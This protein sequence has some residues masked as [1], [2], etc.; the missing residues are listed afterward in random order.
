MLIPLVAIAQL[1][2]YLAS[3]PL[4]GAF[5]LST[6]N[7]LRLG[8]G[9]SAFE[10]GVAL[11]RARQGRPLPKPRDRMDPKRSWQVVKRLR[12]ADIRLHGSLGL[13]DAAATAWACGALR[14]LAAALGAHAGR[15]EVDVAPRFDGADLHVE[16]TGMIRLR[17]GQIMSAIARDGIDHIHRRIAQWTDTRLK[18]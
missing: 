4:C 12:G 16:L 18:A 15:V 7:G 14:A 17:T 10:R 6:R 3:I 5:S 11:R 9:V 8:V 13:G 2:L 1:M